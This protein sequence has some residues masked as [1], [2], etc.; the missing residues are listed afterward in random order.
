MQ[1]HE[2]LKELRLGRQAT[3]WDL[4]KIM[5]ITDRAFRHYEAGTREPTIAGLIALSQFFGV[6]IDY[7]VGVD[8]VPNRRK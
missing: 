3:Q 7:L 1:F 2:R 4:A 5:K 6:S 8:D